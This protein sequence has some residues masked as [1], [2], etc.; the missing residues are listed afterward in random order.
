[1]TNREEAIKDIFKDLR[2][3]IS[4][5]PHLRNTSAVMEVKALQIILEELESAVRTH[6]VADEEE[7]SEG[8]VTHAIKL[9]KKEGKLNP[10]AV[11]DFLISEHKIDISIPALKQ[12]INYMYGD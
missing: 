9:F 1:M 5:L 2:T 3:R 7:I 8:V 10:Q 6:L 11:R 12:R 4:G